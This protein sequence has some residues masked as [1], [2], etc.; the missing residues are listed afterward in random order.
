MGIF[1]RLFG[2]SQKYIYKEL[3]DD[4]VTLL[5]VALF[6]RIMSKYKDHEGKKSQLIA[7]AILNYIT[8]EKPTNE[9]G[10]LFL[11]DNRS[12]IE[13]ETRKLIQENSEIRSAVE[14]LL[15]SEINLIAISTGDVSSEHIIDLSSRAIDIGVQIPVCNN[16]GEMYAG[17]VE[18]IDG[19]CTESDKRI[20]SFVRKEGRP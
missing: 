13:Q 7:G 17:I 9:D 2:K 3:L 20:A 1:G 12:F 16:P 8:C 18:F 10:R 6:S 14:M 5:R 4:Y 11:E 19:F 15:L